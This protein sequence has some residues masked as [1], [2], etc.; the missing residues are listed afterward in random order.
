LGGDGSFAEKTG[1]VS[2]EQQRKGPTGE[3]L[4]IGGSSQKKESSNMLEE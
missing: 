4:K 1:L 3:E 2:K